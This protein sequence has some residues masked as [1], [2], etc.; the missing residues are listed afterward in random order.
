M[1]AFRREW[2]FLRISGGIGRDEWAQVRWVRC[3]QN[4]RYATGGVGGVIGCEPRFGAA[5]ARSSRVQF[6]ILYA[7]TS[8]DKQRQQ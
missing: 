2:D 6:V 3:S 7:T 5:V 8:E 1:L 4:V